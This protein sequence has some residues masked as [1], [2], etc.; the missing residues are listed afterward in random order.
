MW[1]DF[2][3]ETAV[4]DALRARGHTL[5]LRP[6]LVVWQDRGR[7]GLRYALRERFAWARLYAGRRCSEV[8]PLT[9]WL[10]ALGAPLL[11]GLLLQRQV[12]VALRR[13]RHWARHDS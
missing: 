10:L 9:R 1:R 12:R 2:Y 3:N 8:T 4:H 11:G 5:W 13:G 7:I 6:D